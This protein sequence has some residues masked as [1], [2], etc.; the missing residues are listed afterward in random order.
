MRKKMVAMLLIVSQSAIT[1]VQAE[2]KCIKPNEVEAD[3]IRYIETQLKVAALQC[4]GHQYVNM[5][6]FYNDF[7]LE[8]RPYLVRTQKPLQAYLKRVGEGE[9]ISTYM[10]SIA[11][12]VSIESVEVSQFCN[13]AMLAAGFSAKT[14]HPVKLLGLMP[15]EYRRPAAYC[16]VRG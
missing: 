6:L 2:D 9:T 16:R 13:R 7:L 5:P 11:T 15:V 8:N 3:Q 14:A 12:R 1:G 10:D 4:K